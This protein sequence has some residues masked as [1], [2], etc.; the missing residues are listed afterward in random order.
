MIEA[1][2]IAFAI[3]VVGGSFTAV[4]AWNELQDRETAVDGRVTLRRDMEAAVTTI[5][6]DLRAIA[7][8]TTDGA[9]HSK[10]LHEDLAPLCKSLAES[11]TQRMSTIDGD[12]ADL[13]TRVERAT[14][15][16]TMSL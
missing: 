14:G 15:T 6:A 8:A 1:G 2:I 5:A 12:M 3:L 11:L 13:R 16:S 9:Y 10:R 7:H 4:Y